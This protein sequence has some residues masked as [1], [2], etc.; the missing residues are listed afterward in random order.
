[1]VADLYLTFFL[2]S[3]ASLEGKIRPSV[4]SSVCPSV[5]TSSACPSVC[6]FVCSSVQP[7]VGITPSNYCSCSS[8]YFTHFF[9]KIF[10][11]LLSSC[12]ACLTIIV[13]SFH[14]FLQPFKHTIKAH[15]HSLRYRICE[16]QKKNMKKRWSHVE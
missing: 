4:L 15:F 14:I 7:R 16:W 10:P 6:L 11:F 3:N 2:F 9:P 1:M 12:F 13:C 5:C 8:Q